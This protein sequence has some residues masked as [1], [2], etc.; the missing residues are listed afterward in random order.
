MKE[1]SKK[2]IKTLLAFAV[3]L[4]IV[5]AF[6][7]ANVADSYAANFSTSGTVSGIYVSSYSESSIN[8]KW[9]SYSMATGY[10]VYKASSKDGSYTL[11]STVTSP[12]FGR[13]GLTS[14]KTCYYKVRAYFRNSNG[15]NS[16]SGY[17]AAI[18]ATPIKFS[19]SKV[20]GFKKAKHT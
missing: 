19:D 12:K 10:E 1:A 3:S 15:T 16:Y 5:V 14:G 8:L 11:M 6:M 9:N 7:P 13:S 4:A 20:G 18:A 17:S 2:Y